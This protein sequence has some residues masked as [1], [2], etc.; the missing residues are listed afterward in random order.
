MSCTEVLPPGRP[1]HTAPVRWTSCPTCRTSD[2]WSDGMTEQEVPSRRHAP[3]WGAAGVGTGVVAGV[4]S[5]RREGA[6]GALRDARGALTDQLAGLRDRRRVEL[7]GECER[8]HHHGHA[9]VLV[10]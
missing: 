7:R 8:A 10:E 6:A 2:L 5:V 4:W 3:L 1:R 9:A